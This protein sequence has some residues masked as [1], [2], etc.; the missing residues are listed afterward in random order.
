MA[1]YIETQVELAEQIADW[2]GVYGAGPEGDH[3]LDCKCRL[4]FVAMVERRIRESVA[5]E[6]IVAA[7]RE[8][9]G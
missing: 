4:C 1:P 9:R 6:S 8:G 2:A 3:P 5:N 7:R